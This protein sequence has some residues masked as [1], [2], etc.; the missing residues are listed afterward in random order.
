[1][2]NYRRAFFLALV[3]NVVFI[4]ILAE[5]WW[6]ARRS[7]KNQHPATSTSTPV[8]Q[9]VQSRSPGS[10]PSPVPLETPLAPVQ[11]SAERL[12]SIGVKFGRVERKPVQDEIR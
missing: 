6:T 12:Q 4:G 11:L 10:A 8:T 2:R 1:M 7:A 5:I 3:G 9:E